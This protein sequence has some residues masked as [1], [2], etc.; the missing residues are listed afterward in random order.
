MFVEKNVPLNIENLKKE[1]ATYTNKEIQSD[2]NI[3]QVVQFIKLEHIY[4][5]ALEEI[6]TKLHILD[7]DFQLKNAHNPIHHM[8]RRVKKIPSLLQ[9]LKRKGFEI[10]AESAQTH[11]MDIAGIRVVCNYMNDIYNVEQ[12]LLQQADIKLL[13]R[14]DYI[15]YPK[16]NGYKSLHIVVSVPVFLTDGTIEAPVE[17]QL[18]TIGMDMWASLEHQLH[19]KSSNGDR[20][21]YRQTLRECALEI[22]DVE[23]KMER[24]HLNIQQDQI[25]EQ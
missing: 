18:R 24:I 14:K 15:Q 23:R 11:I 4:G 2:D 16:T 10:S 1:V 17:I 19:Y 9:K 25:N 22:G 12:L 20:A 13:K 5:A 7:Q 8:E 3:E 6:S 21:M